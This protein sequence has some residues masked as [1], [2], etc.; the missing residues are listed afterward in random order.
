MRMLMT[1]GIGVD[2]SMPVPDSVD[3]PLEQP[4]GRVP[5]ERDETVDD[6]HEDEE[7][8]TS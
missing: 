1:T 5:R 7:E 2:E 6:E 8:E 4:P 3:V